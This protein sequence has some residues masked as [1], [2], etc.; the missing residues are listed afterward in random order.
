M[1]IVGEVVFCVVI[2]RLPLAQGVPG[3]VSTCTKQLWVQGPTQS[4][5]WEVQPV[6][7]VDSLVMVSGGRVSLTCCGSCEGLSG[8]GYGCDACPMK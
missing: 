4:H 6:P 5:D 7:H 8:Q 3:R 2:F 1:S